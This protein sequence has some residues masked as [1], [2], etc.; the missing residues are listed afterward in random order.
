MAD[1]SSD[2]DD[3]DMDVLAI[4]SSLPLHIRHV[5]PQFIS[6]CYRTIVLLESWL[7]MEDDETIAACGRLYAAQILF[8]ARR[9]TMGVR[10][11]SRSRRIVDMRYRFGGLLFIL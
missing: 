1:S 6:S 2:S 11:G 9:L 5:I 3:E 10:G 8:L 4:Q 7:D